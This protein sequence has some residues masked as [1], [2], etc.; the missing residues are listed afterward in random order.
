MPEMNH[1]RDAA[2]AGKSLLHL[3]VVLAA[4]LL[5][6]SRV[7]A[8]GGTELSRL[9]AE[10]NRAYK[11]SQYE[12]AARKYEQIIQYGIHNAA[13][14]YNLGNARFKL[15]HLGQAILNY[16]KARR[17]DPGDADI[18]ENLAFSS[19]MRVDKVDEPETPLW[20]VML[21]MLHNLIRLKSQ[22]AALIVLWLLANAGFAL[23]FVRRD[24]LSRRV[25]AYVMA[26]ALLLLLP[27]ALSAGVKIRQQSQWEGVVVT[28]KAD[29]LSGP[30]EGNP[31]LVSVH[32]GLKV[33]I[34][35]EVSGW[36]QV[37]LPNGWNGWVRRSA[38]EPL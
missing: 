3:L 33:E 6:A 8:Q 9:F 36:Y 17:L 10:A 11:Q 26:G 22:L 34:R 27:T 30:G 1:R 13:V 4:V 31:V 5:C 16:E 25:A 35:S 28:E 19:A 38:L 18:A 20:M 29:L 12:E 24:E 15:N 21:S 7:A 37:V 14:Y 2:G 32:E 23:R